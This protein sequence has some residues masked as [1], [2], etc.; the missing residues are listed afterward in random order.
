M[1]VFVWKRII[2]KTI[3]TITTKT[4]TEITKIITITKITI[5]SLNLPRDLLGGFYFYIFSFSSIIV[6][7]PSFKSL[8]FICAPN[9]P[10]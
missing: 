1:E 7:G 5:D 10:V 4:T 3:I 9:S 6:T 2:T 8:T